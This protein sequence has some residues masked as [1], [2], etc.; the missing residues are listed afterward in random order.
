MDIGMKGIV[1]DQNIVNIPEGALNVM[2]GDYIYYVFIIYTS[3]DEKNE[4][5]HCHP[6]PLLHGSLAGSEA[7]KIVHVS[8]TKDFLFTVLPKWFWLYGMY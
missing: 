3:G 1:H 2:F 5:H 4:N 7:R 6:L 8:L